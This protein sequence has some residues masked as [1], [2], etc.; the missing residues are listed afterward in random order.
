MTE[1]VNRKSLESKQR[2][3]DSTQH[4][5]ESRCNQWIYS[6]PGWGGDGGGGGG[7]PYEKIGMLVLPFEVLVPFRVR[8]TRRQQFSADRLGAR[9]SVE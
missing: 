2:C 5:K 6:I 1:T 8:N 7:V 9:V 4:R 3:N